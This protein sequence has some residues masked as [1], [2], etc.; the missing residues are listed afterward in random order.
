M[1]IF[2]GKGKCITC[3][4]GP[5]FTGAGFKLQFTQT[6]NQESVV[7]RMSMGDF[8]P[9]IY[10]NGFYNIGVAPTNRD[11]GIGADDPFGHPCLFP[12]SSNSRSAGRSCLIA[13]SSIPAYS[14]TNPAY[15]SRARSPAMPLTGPS[16]RPACG[17]W[18]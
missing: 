3:H 2:S 14:G 16:K 11:L 7:Q 13:S 12:G 10:D 1:A 8:N 15:R 6:I 18:N 4:E 17:T 9:A 5:D